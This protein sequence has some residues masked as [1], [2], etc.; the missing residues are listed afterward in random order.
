MQDSFSELAQRLHE[1]ALQYELQPSLNFCANEALL[2]AGARRFL[3]STLADVHQE[4][5][6]ATRGCANQTASTAGFTFRG[7]PDLY[8]L[9]A[10]ILALFNSSIHA[11]LTDI[12]LSSGMHAMI[13]TLLCVT[14]PGDLVLSI[15]PEDGGHFATASILAR[16]GRR[17]DYLGWDNERLDLNFSGLARCAGDIAAVYLDQG[18]PLYP[19]DL[20][21]IRTCVG[22]NTVIIYD[23]SHTLGLIAGGCFQSP[24]R[25]G[26][27]ILQGNTHKT[28]PGPQKAIV[29]IADPDFG[30]TLVGSM[31]AGFVSSQ[32]THHVLALLMAMLETLEHGSNFA[33]RSIENAQYLSAQLGALGFSLVQ[34]GSE[35]TQTNQVLIA[36]ESFEELEAYAERLGMIHIHANA[37]KAYGRNILRLGTQH[38][39]RRGMG[40]AE[41]DIVAQLLREAYDGAS[42]ARLDAIVRELDA[43]FRSV[44]FSFDAQR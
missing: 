10:E 43:A 37:K 34:R 1:T 6:T 31:S 25:E 42:V 21:R 40:R 20:A 2:S 11:A 17:H 39:T 19:L 28:F 15:R 7:L 22:P 33:R 4:G 35:P 23:A 12:R 44:A 18:T 41:L 16:A 26:A 13:V 29:A 30:Q 38:V 9:E 36:F 3:S 27:D 14:A 32:H 8:E 24:L 5:T